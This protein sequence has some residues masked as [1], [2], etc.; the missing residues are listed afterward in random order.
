MSVSTNQSTVFVSFDQSQTGKEIDNL[1]GN[2][3]D[4]CP[5]SPVD[6]ANVAN[7]GLPLGLINP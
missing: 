3:I 2:M 1:H 4:S 5:L 6:I 7:E